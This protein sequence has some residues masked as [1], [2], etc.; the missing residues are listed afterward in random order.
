MY[1]QVL[2]TALYLSFAMF[3]VDV[4]WCDSC[5]SLWDAADMTMAFYGDGWHGLI[6]PDCLRHWLG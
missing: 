3:G 6:C 1:V 5:G 4:S 2:T